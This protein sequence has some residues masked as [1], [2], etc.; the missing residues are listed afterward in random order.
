[1]NV[2]DLCA[3]LAEAG[4]SPPCGRKLSLGRMRRI[5]RTTVSLRSVTSGQ[6]CDY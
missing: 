4:L 2:P 1:M 5:R 6:F 3:R